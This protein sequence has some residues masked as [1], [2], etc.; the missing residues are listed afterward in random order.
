MD[1]V[2]VLESL[3]SKVDPKNL[4]F[5]SDLVFK[6]KKYGSLSLKQMFW[7]NKFVAE[8]QGLVPAKPDEELI[9]GFS[10]VVALLDRAKVKLKRPKINLAVNGQDVVLSVAGPRAKKPGTINVT[11]GRPFGENVWFGRIDSKGWWEHNA[12]LPEAKVAPV[13][14]LLQDLGED[15]VGTAKKY[16]TLTGNCCFCNKKLTDEHSTAA[17]FGEVCAKN[18]GLHQEWKSA[19]SVLKA[20]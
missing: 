8:A 3:L 4:K 15:P 10:G 14:K 20:A 9:V 5:A 6:G 7:V 11:D 2:L 12:R 17:G 16:A 1:Q 19:S 13:R 18:W